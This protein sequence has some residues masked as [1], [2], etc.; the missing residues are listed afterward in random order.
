MQAFGL[1]VSSSKS[2]GHPSVVK[3]LSVS[4][5][6][7]AESSSE[8]SSK[9]E[10]PE[11]HMRVGVEVVRSS[12]GLSHIVLESDHASD[13]GEGGSFDSPGDI[14]VVAQVEEVKV[15]ELGVVLNQLDVSDSAAHV[16]VL[17]LLVVGV[18]WDCMSSVWAHLSSY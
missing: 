10:S 5:F 9:H 15:E 3:S 4:E 13:D 2:L 6:L 12:S 11:A 1:G 18:A 17:L 7:E 14:E 8:R 16:G